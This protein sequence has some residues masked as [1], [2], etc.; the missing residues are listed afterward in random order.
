MIRLNLT[1]FLPFQG[2]MALM[3]A[4]SCFISYSEDGDIVARSKTAKEEEMI[5]A[6]CFPGGALY[7]EGGHGVGL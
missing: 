4:N 1:A 5:K 2:K 7:P 6:K 3:A